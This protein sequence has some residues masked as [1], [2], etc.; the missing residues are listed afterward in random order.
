MLETSETDG[1][2]PTLAQLERALAEPRVRGILINSPSNPSGRVWPEERVHALVELCRKHDCWILSDEIYARIGY[3]GPRP[4]SP[5]ECPGG[6]ECTAVL[7]GLSKAR[8]PRRRHRRTIARFR[9]SAVVYLGMNRASAA[10]GPRKRVGRPVSSRGQ[11]IWGEP[12]TIADR[13]A[14]CSGAGPGSRGPR[15]Y[16]AG[17]ARA[18]VPH[19]AAL[20]GDP[21]Q[22]GQHRPDGRR[23]RLPAPRRSPISF[24]MS[25]KG[26]SPGRAHYWDM[27]DCREHDSWETFLRAERPER[28]WLYTTKTD[29]PHWTADLRLG[30]YLL[31]GRE[32]AGVPDEIRRSS[33]RRTAPTIASRCRWCPGRAA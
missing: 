8:L 31:F 10:V 23:D 5:A 4:I 21:E 17:R 28:L 24:D 15:R 20:P 25:E 16:T 2:V 26:P 22:H 19:R 9:M 1:F 3:G 12:R 6:R 14:P 30:D 18:A 7:N 32:T 11:G 13:R 27:V 33:K 29:R